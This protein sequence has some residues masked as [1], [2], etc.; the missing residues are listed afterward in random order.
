MIKICFVCLG[1]I[2]RSPMA[3]MIMKNKVKE[4]HLENEFVIESRATSYEEDG[5]DIY[6]PVKKVLDE[7]N[8][9]YT[10]HISRRLEKEDFNKFDYFIGMDD[11]NIRQINF[12]LNNNTKTRKLLEKDILDPWYTRDFEKAYQDINK[13]IQELLEKI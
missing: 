3:E 7:H 4:K 10:N 8:I 5:N 9:S 1:N 12:I 11:N 13:G 2:C 6:P